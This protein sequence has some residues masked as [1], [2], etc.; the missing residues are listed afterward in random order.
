MKLP[1][2]HGTTQALS[3]RPN[4]PTKRCLETLDN[5]HASA[6]AREQHSLQHP[7]DA[8]EALSSI[9]Q[10]MRMPNLAWSALWEPFHALQATITDLKASRTT[11]YK[12]ICSPTRLCFRNQ[13]V[14]PLK[15]VPSHS[16][17]SQTKPLTIY[18]ENPRRKILLYKSES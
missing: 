2:I 12:S 4:N 14:S 8:H 15:S 1:S 3:C 9:L 16:F 17:S 10:Q 13:T 18:D 6:T 5:T 7:A 11:E